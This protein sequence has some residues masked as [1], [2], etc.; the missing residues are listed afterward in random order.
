MVNDLCK[1]LRETADKL[2]AKK[3]DNAANL[4]EQAMRDLGCD[5]QMTTQGGGN[6]NGPPPLPDGPN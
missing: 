1:S 6:G 2:R 3:L 4:I 5:D